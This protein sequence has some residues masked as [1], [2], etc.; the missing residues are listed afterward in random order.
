MQKAM[1]EDCA[2]FRTGE[3]LDKGVKRLEAVQAKRTGAPW[4]AAIGTA[5]RQA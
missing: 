4:D 5:E 1:Q 3:T 2:V